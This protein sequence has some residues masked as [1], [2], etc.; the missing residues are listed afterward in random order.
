MLIP[1]PDCVCEGKLG[2]IGIRDEVKTA[3]RR[4]YRHRL[5][6]PTMD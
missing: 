1:L 2:A 3:R 5:I 4:P 6:Q